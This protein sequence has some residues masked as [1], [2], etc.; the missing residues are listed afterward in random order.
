MTN[1]IRTPIIAVVGHVDA[2]KTSLLDKIRS[3]NVVEKEA[4]R[5]T[6]H[7]GATEIPITLIQTIAGPLLTKFGFVLNIPGLLFIDTPGHEA[8]TNLRER[9]SSIADLAVLVIDVNKGLQAQTKEAITILR[10]YKVPFAIALTKLDLI[11]NYESAPGSFLANLSQ[12]NE[13]A[14]AKLD[15]RLYTIVGQVFEAGFQSERF[16]RVKDPTKEI[17]MIPISSHTGEGMPEL[18]MF[19]AGLSQKFLEQK[20]GF[21]VDGPAKGTVLEVRDER[22]FGKTIDVILY[23]GSLSVGDTIVLAGKNGVIKTKVRALLQPNTMTDIRVADKF[24]SLPEAHAATGIKIAAPGLDDAIAGSSVLEESTGNESAEILSEVNRIRIE[25]DAIGIIV[26]ADTLGSLEALIQ[27]LH[28]HKI[29]IKRADVGEITRRDVLEAAALKSKDPYAGCVLGFNAPI[30]DAVKKD[31]ELQQVKI[32]SG[33]IVYALTE[34]YQQW[35]KETEENKH[36]GLLEKAIFPCQLQLMPNHIFRNTKPAVVG[37]RIVEG[38]L[39]VG[40]ELMNKHGE[41]IGKVAQIQQ[42][43]E[44]IDLAERNDEVAISIDGGNVGRNLFENETLYTNPTPGMLMLLKK[45]ESK[46]SAEEKELLEKIT[47]LQSSLTP[48]QEEQ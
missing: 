40:T 2:G 35:V 36:K 38:R 29:K 22:G 43:K 45:I 18:L 15:E 34:H 48:N 5:I 21:A 28:S 27:L 13:K 10:N 17:G 6:Q 3:T 23:D 7:I 9:G 14:K 26:K 16:D 11:D 31:A 44:N 37:V 42:D 25:S 20:L 41:V 24:I 19:L 32:I 30:L 12:Q 1:A 46:L 8:F 33:N 4:G 39:R 47:A